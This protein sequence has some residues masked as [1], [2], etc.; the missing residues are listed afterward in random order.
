MFTTVVLRC[1][2]LAVWGLPA[3]RA[4]GASAR[5]RWHKSQLTHLGIPSVA[6]GGAGDADRRGEAGDRGWIRT[7]LDVVP[8]WAQAIVAVLALLG[9]GA[10][11]AIVVKGTSGTSTP[12][13]TTAP[14]P[15]GPATPVYLSDLQPQGGDTPTRGDTQIGDQDFPHSIFYDN[16]PDNQ[17]S[18]SACQ[19]DADPTC[20]ATDYSI[21]SARYRQ[22]SAML[23]ISDGCSGDT[24][25]WSLTVDGV[26]VKSGP[27]TVNA[28]PHPI[29]V[30][31]PRGNSLE[32]LVSDSGFS[33]A[34]CGG[35]NI[36]WGD[37]Q[38]S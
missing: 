19:K 31:I 2:C 13:P 23:G 36:I 16:V 12:S 29:A 5:P 9:V 4:A 20:Q 18:A 32:L 37:A 15:A 1:R 35:I 3:V 30:A 17:S 6:M 7:V 14:P 11:G 22:F 28:S 34:A 24:A 27:V 21:A 33:G 26:V 10:G 8:R 25:S 38:L